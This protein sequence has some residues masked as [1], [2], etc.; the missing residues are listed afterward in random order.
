MIDNFLLEG[1]ARLAFISSRFPTLIIIYPL[2]ALFHSVFVTITS[3]C[4]SHRGLLLVPETLQ[5]ILY[6]SGVLTLNSR[7]CSGEFEATDSSKYSCATS[8]CV[9]VYRQQFFILTL[10]IEQR[11]SRLYFHALKMFN[12]C[13]VY[14]SD[15]K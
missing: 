14:S 12:C 3:V 8:Y 7:S 10:N 4:L 15:M 5:R 9:R 2:G 1:K 13:R 6:L 11:S